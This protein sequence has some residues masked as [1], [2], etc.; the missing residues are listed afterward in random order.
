MVLEA[1]SEDSP[2]RSPF[3]ENGLRKSD[4][5]SPTRPKPSRVRRRS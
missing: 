2:P 1:K 5:A 3:H 4:S